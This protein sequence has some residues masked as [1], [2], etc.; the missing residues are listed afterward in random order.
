MTRPQSIRAMRV[1]S[2]G[3]L[4]SMEDVPLRPLREHEV[5]IKVSACGV[6]RTD[7]HLRDGELPNAHYPVTPGHEI[8][9]RIGE[10]GDA[11]A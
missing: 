7:L 6:C 4:L 8:V 10:L 11:V 5:L 1:V 9:G 3:C 2:P